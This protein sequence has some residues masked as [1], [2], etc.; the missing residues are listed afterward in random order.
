[1]IICAVM[2]AINE[3]SD[4]QSDIAGH[5]WHRLGSCS[6]S[7]ILSSGF[8]ALFAAFLSSTIVFG[9]EK[10]EPVWQKNSIMLFGLIGVVAFNVGLAGSVIALHPLSP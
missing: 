7:R 6:S 3:Q 1:M 8:P 5:L 4:H 10:T 2:T 9:G